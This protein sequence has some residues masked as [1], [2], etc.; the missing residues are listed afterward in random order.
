MF[1]SKLLSW[2]LAII[3]DLPSFVKQNQ[4]QPVVI[5]SSLKISEDHINIFNTG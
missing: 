5:L 2:K 1:I 3:G 4:N